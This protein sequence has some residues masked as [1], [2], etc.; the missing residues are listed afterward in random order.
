MANPL[1]YEE[2]VARQ[3]NRFDEQP[4]AG[5]ENQPAIPE[6]AQLWFALTPFWTIS[7]AQ[8]CSFP[9]GGLSVETLFDQMVQVGLCEWTR[10]TAHTEATSKGKAPRGDRRHYR[11]VHS[12]RAVVLRSVMQDTRRGLPV[13]VTH[14]S[15]IGRGIVAAG[16]EG[17]PV[18]SSLGRWAELAAAASDHRQV[19]RLLTDRVLDN[20]NA[21]NTG[22]ALAWLEAALPIQELL[23]GDVSVGLAGADRRLEL[24]QR[25]AYDER[26]LE[27]FLEREEQTAAFEALLWDGDCDHWALHFIGAGGVGKT[28]LVQHLS[29]KLTREEIGSHA[30]IDFDHLNPSYPARTPGLLLDHL[31]TELR[32]HDRNNQAAETFLKFDERVVTLHELFG[33]TWGATSPWPDPLDAIGTREFGQLLSTFCDA[34]RLLPQPVVLILDTCEELAKISF[35]GEVP[36]SVDVTFEILR[37]LHETLPELRVVFCGRRPL[38]SVGAGWAIPGSKHP[39]REYL[40]LHEIR[41]FTH[42]EAVRYLREKADVPDEFVEQIVRLSPETGTTYQLETGDPAA[43]DGD[44]RYNP[45]ELSSFAALV[46]ATPTLTAEDLERAADPTHY[47]R[48]RIID[49]I[50]YAPLRQVLPAVALLGRF[51]W[52]T[53][54]AAAASPESFEVLFQELSDQE[55]IDRLTNGF[56]EVQPSL[57]PR[58]LAYF[59]GPTDGGLEAMRRRQEID[60]A[61]ERAAVYLKRRTENEP[62]E[63]LDIAHFEAMFRLLQGQPERAAEWWTAIEGRFAGAGTAGYEWAVRLIERLFADE[64]TAPDAPGHAVVGGDLEAAVRATEAAVLIHARPLVDLGPIW[65]LVAATAARHPGEADRERLQLRA[66]AGGIAATRNATTGMNEHQRQELESVL[67]ALNETLDEQLG[68]SLIAA[69]ETVVER[70]E[71]AERQDQEAIS[72]D[73][74]AAG[75]LAETL[76]ATENAELAAFACS[77]TGRVCRLA[78]RHRAAGSWFENAMSRRPPCGPTRQRWLDWL[79]PDDLGA[80]I[81]LEYVRGMYPAALSPDDVAAR[82]E[83]SETETI[84]GDRLCSALLTLRGAVAPV[85]GEELAH[86]RK[87]LPTSPTGNRAR[88]NAHDAFPPLFATVAEAMVDRGEV[89]PALQ[90]LEDHSDAAEST[91]TDFDTVQAAER[92]RLRIERRLRLRD[93]K[94][95]IS[96]S[97]SQ[98]Q[99]TDDWAL[100]WALEGLD[101][102]KTGVAISADRAEPGHLPTS[103]VLARAHANWRA[104]YGLRSSYA[105]ML[106]EWAAS[107]LPSP[108]QMPGAPEEDRRA[109]ELD[110]IEALLVAE[111]NEIDVPRPLREAAV[112]S[113]S[114]DLVASVTS[115][116]DE[117]PTAAVEAYTILL[118]GTALD[119]R[120]T[121]DGTAVGRDTIFRDFLIDRIGR[122]RA[123]AIALDE[124]EL[125]A[126]RL[127]EQAISM[128]T[129]ALELYAVSGDR[130][131]TFIA[132]TCVALVLA[133]LRQKAPL[134]SI[135]ARTLD[136]YETYRTGSDPSLPSCKQLKSAI[137]SDDGSVIDF[138]YALN[139]N[140]LRPWLTRLVACME[141]LEELKGGTP[142]TGDV[143]AW[144][145]RYYG[146]ARDD[147]IAVPAE[148]DAWVEPPLESVKGSP[149]RKPWLYRLRPVID[150]SRVFVFVIGFLAVVFVLN[151]FWGGRTV[152]SV[153]I[154]GAVGAIIAFL[155]EVIARVIYLSRVGFQLTVTRETTKLEEILNSP[156]GTACRL[157]RGVPTSRLMTMV[158]RLFH[159]T[160]V[161]IRVNAGVTGDGPYRR[162]AQEASQ[163]LPASLNRARRQVLGRAVP[164]EL[165]I[166]PSLTAI[167]WEAFVALAGD[168]PDVVSQRDLP[169][170]FSRTLLGVTARPLTPPRSATP[171]VY[172]FSSDYAQ[173]ETARTAWETPVKRGLI[174]HSIGR[175]LVG[176]ETADGVLVDVLHV[177]A[178]PVET[179]AG[180]RLQVTGGQASSP[181]RRSGDPAAG[182]GEMMTAT[183]VIRIAPAMVLCILQ[184]PPRSGHPRNNSDRDEASALRIAAADLH[185]AGVAAVLTVPSLPGS[186]AVAALAAFAKSGFA[187]RS[188]RRA[189]GVAAAAVRNAIIADKEMDAEARTEAALDVCLY[190]P[191]AQ[192]PTSS[193]G[194]VLKEMSSVQK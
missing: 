14:L 65:E 145:N 103:A 59:A 1:T 56:L 165:C 95:T 179:S 16:S 81:Q 76:M 29:A 116:M 124:G 132:G 57:R 37:R 89:D 148:F 48:L 73:P 111:L 102:P 158:A 51:D 36:R 161:R 15:T 163:H 72:L 31:A 170:R 105:T 134:D 118:R 144:V 27:L 154:G 3:G 104:F 18:P 123:A 184:A 110:R 182:R 107:I 21:K 186:T 119:W 114:A 153:L 52:E 108:Y 23:G 188:S 175:L 13:A 25:L 151:R 28:M 22:E 106:V 130:Q 129:A 67:L 160:S 17:L 75:H 113:R 92:A 162:S 85:D 191:G 87:M 58:M 185:A 164:L 181:P 126:L 69:V 139:G 54:S 11:I 112:G 159:A 45:Y 172:T 7:L 98:S 35:D 93:E 46:R 60:Q 135:L 33:G 6:D 178:T 152:E 167:C 133:R 137:E 156:L 50:Q 9:A 77:L 136:D 44:E 171:H 26:R 66:L 41:G 125:L 86:A 71:R 20:L 187:G 180:V 138:L 115:W 190:L 55:W 143:F 83:W 47:V 78:D 64:G 32:L 176:R 183:D 42:D 100:L 39:A 40:R 82:I 122:R 79:A 5:G 141:R 70:A 96:S 62:L 80:R 192:A 68:A 150:D 24:A 90:L 74:A 94:R 169:W 142:P 63:S 49:R 30:R 53:L 2:A 117:R 8:R 61:G 146:T 168:D 19:A 121:A 101:G 173:G 38:A 157:E 193:P 34:A 12:A 88:A 4:F 128:L 43:S 120:S 97:L 140:P 147:E 99:R 166:D 149:R 91:A 189:L 177:V 155:S 10:Q 127:P 174:E 84:D 109:I 131:G 194:L